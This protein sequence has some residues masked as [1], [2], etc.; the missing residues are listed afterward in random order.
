MAF[1]LYGSLLM[2]IGFYLQSVGV[3]AINS[4]SLV[5]KGSPLTGGIRLYKDPSEYI[6]VVGV[7][8][9]H[10]KIERISIRNIEP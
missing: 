3:R 10:L 1:V 8:F 9:H 4:I 7:S 6:K 5:L 2:S